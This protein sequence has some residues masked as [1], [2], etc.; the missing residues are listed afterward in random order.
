[1]VLVDTSVW[2]QHFRSSQQR[3][4][5]LLLEDQVLTHSCIIGEL[6]CGSLAKREEILESLSALPA[7]T[8]AQDQE[9]LEF[10]ERYHC[11]G[12]G[13]GWVDT[14]LLVAARLSRAELWTRDKALARVWADLRG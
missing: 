11:Y 8:E 10:I 12:T 4:E 14:Q 2:I 6:A 5:H 1:M 3:L 7:A 9:V 13:I